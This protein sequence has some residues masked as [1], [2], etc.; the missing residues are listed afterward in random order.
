MNISINQIVTALLELEAKG[1]HR[2]FFEYGTDMFRLKI[3][4]GEI[5]VESIAFER[6]IPLCGQQTELDQLFEYIVNLSHHVKTT[7]FQCYCRDFIK[8]VKAGIWKKI[9]PVFEFGVNATSGMLIDGS[10]YY[11]HDPDNNRQY[12]V[13]MMQLSEPETS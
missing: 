2:V 8:G 5:S 3:F 11:V 10:G 12:F 4:R 1:C 6:T 13:D 9:K 7:S